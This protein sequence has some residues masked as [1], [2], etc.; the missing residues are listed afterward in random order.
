MHV[1]FD[2]MHVSYGNLAN[3]LLDYVN[4]ITKCISNF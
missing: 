3:K 2:K 4:L 1:N